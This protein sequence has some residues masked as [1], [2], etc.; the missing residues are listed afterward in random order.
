MLQIFPK[1]HDGEILKR[2][3]DGVDDCDYQ[4]AYDP[5]EH[6]LITYLGDSRQLFAFR[7]D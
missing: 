2:F 6:M 3:H 1:G 4:L 7:I 5:L